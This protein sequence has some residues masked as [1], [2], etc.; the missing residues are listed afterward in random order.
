MQIYSVSPVLFK[1]Q[2]FVFLQNFRAPNGDYST[3]SL[4]SVKDEVFIN[5]FDE[6]L[7]DV[8]EVSS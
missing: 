6:V 2:F 5:V 8:T 1:S 4:Q 7:H 3:H